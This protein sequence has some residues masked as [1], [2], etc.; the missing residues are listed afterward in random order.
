MLWKSIVLTIVFK[1]LLVAAQQNITCVYNDQVSFGYNCD[2]YIMNPNGVNNF[3][4]IGGAHQVNRVNANVNRVRGMS[5]EGRM[6]ENV[7]SILCQQFMHLRIIS[8][9][10]LGIT[11]IL[12]NSFYACDELNYLDLESNYIRNISEYAFVSTPKLE[13]LSLGSNQMTSFSE[14]L[15][16]D[17]RNLTYLSLENNPF[18]DIPANAFRNLESLNELR[19]AA[20]EISMLKPEWFDN[21]SELEVLHLGMNRIVELPRDIFLNLDNLKTLWLNNNQ[22]TV[23]V[24]IAFGNMDTLT[25]VN[26]DHNLINGTD[27]NFL[28]FTENLKW[29]YFS[30]NLC[31]NEIFTDF[32][33]NRDYNMNTYFLECM[34]NYERAPFG[35][36]FSSIVYFNANFLSYRGKHLQ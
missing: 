17:L 19:L 1:L 10:S 27:Y 21:L 33:A 34:K 8:L 35:K 31:A 7:P 12:P 16:D 4:G 5:G 22:L 32:K 13:F 20:C 28:R 6:T 2:L 25:E 18:Q 30:N 23:V 36:T 14:N 26:F 24:S 29:L 15:F 3:V 9:N 11:T